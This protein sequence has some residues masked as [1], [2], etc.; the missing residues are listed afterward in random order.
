MNGYKYLQKFIEKQGNANVPAIS[1]I[2]DFNLGVWI[3]GQRYSYKQGKLSLEKI[4]LLENLFGWTWVP[5]NE[6]W[7][8]GYNKLMCYYRREGH[9]RVPFDHVEDSFNL[10]EW[11]LTQRKAYKSGKVEKYRISKLESLNGWV[12]NTR[13]KA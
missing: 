1:K 3:G 11:V 7:L 6:Q 12:W 8:N 2:D 9:A 13:K 5:K 10:G 4:S